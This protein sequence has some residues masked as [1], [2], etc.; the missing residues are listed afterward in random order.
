MLGL[1]AVGDIQVTKLQQELAAVAAD[2]D[3]LRSE[4][5]RISSDCAAAKTRLVSVEG[6]KAGLEV[7]HTTTGSP[8]LPALQT[9]SQPVYHD[10]SPSLLMS[11][12]CGTLLSSHCEPHPAAGERHP[13]AEACLRLDGINHA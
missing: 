1:A 11:A 4:V 8:S 9:R 13:A 3:Q 10:A 12:L 6:V 5:E 2:R 7:I